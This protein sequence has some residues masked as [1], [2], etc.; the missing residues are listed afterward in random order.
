MKLDE[1]VELSDE[2]AHL[3]SFL[4]KGCSQTDCIF[5]EERFVRA[6]AE[7]TGKKSGE[8]AICL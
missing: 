1:A 7:I 2:L 5:Q 8:H 6:D 4:N 3:V